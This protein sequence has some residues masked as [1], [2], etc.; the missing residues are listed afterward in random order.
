VRQQLA[1]TSATGSWS[2]EGAAAVASGTDA[3]PALLCAGGAVAVAA[4]VADGCRDAPWQASASDPRVADVRASRLAAARAVA[5][6]GHDDAYL[7]PEPRGHGVAVSVSHRAGRGA[8]IA[9]RAGSGLLVGVDLELD[10]P[11][12]PARA[13]YFLS[14]AERADAGG[15][16]DLAT[17]WALK[18]AA[19]KA[20]RLDDATPFHA[21]ELGLDR[22]GDLR[23]VSLCGRP[24]RAGA[25]VLAPWPGFVLAALWVEDAP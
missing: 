25:R 23:T 24:R 6:L 18:E 14:A 9:A 16:R 12:P 15:R 4:A 17:L 7:R 22:A 2:H 19:W 5:L 1:A 11:M 20:L 13:R 21:L 8:A 10:V 3:P